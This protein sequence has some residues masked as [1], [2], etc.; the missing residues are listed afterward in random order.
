MRSLRDNGSVDNYRQG[1]RLGES[2]IYASVRTDS[3]SATSVKFLIGAAIMLIGL[4]TY[5]VFDVLFSSSGWLIFVLIPF[6]I[7][8]VVV[9]RKVNGALLSMAWDEY[10]GRPQPVYFIRWSRADCDNGKDRVVHASDI[11]AGDWIC[12]YVLY[13]QDKKDKREAQEEFERKEREHE[14]IEQERRARERERQ[15]N[16]EERLRKARINSIRRSTIRHPDTPTLDTILD[17]NRLKYPLIDVSAGI[18]LEDYSALNVVGRRFYNLFDPS[19]PPKCYSQVIA[20]VRPSADRDDIVFGLLRTDKTTSSFERAYYRLRRPSDLGD[21]E[22]DAD[23]ALTLL[24]DQLSRNRGPVS[25]AD[26]VEGLVSKHHDPYSI[27]RA[28]EASL[29]TGMAERQRRSGWLREVISTTLRQTDGAV[30]HGNCWISLTDSGRIWAE[31][32]RH[33]RRWIVPK[34]CRKCGG[35]VNEAVQAF[36]DNPRC[37]YCGF[38]LDF[39]TYRRNHGGPKL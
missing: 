27:R 28:I 12:D 23:G 17:S 4:I 29:A 13:Q 6:V 20:L 30:G 33:L 24:I 25:E 19:D 36:A 1:Q 31:A 14:R 26:I 32:G 11:E 15:R 18:D 22:E 38:T 35:A 2:L 10:R 3:A 37:V 8:G 5:A 7:A 9:G 16:L 34:E 39:E 21:V